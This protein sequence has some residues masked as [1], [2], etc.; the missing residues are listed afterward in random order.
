MSVEDV[1][2]EKKIVLP[3]VVVP[4]ANYMLASRSGKIVMSSGFTPK[5]NGT[6]TCTGKLN[7][8]RIAEGYQGAR[9]ATL[10][11]LAAL[12]KLCGGLDNIN[13]ILKVSG[14]IVSEDDFHN[15]SK[16]LNGAS[17]LL[18]E[19]FGDAGRHAR[20]AVG[21]SSLFGDASLE[22]TLDVELKDESLAEC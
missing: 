22:I 21:I 10:N 11:A 16:V 4:V 3:E 12:N 18:V 19:I 6:W 2:K 20:F 7:D 8:D 15:Q 17:D 14:Y 9:L 5:A 1:L 13:R